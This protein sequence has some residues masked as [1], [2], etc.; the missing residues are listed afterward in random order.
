MI[1][2][3]VYVT[4]VIESVEFFLVLDILL[5]S[6]RSSQRQSYLAW[7]RQNDMQHFYYRS[8]ITESFVKSTRQTS[9]PFIWNIPYEYLLFDSLQAVDQHDVVKCKVEI[10][11]WYP[12]NTMCRKSH[13][14]IEYNYNTVGH[15]INSQSRCD[16]SPCSS[17]L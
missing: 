11:G 14:F 8:F 15:G 3:T 10:S 12:L 4:P 1:R 2:N 7:R 6:H 16:E 5:N 13:V 17:D 9:V